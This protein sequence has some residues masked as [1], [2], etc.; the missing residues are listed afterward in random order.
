MDFET[1]LSE[2]FYTNYAEKKGDNYFGS[3]YRP[4]ETMQGI[5]IRLN[6]QLLEETNLDKIK[7]IT[8]ALLFIEYIVND[9]RCSA[10]YEKHLYG[11][12]RYD[13]R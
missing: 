6:T 8:K 4:G 11:Q 5:I 3:M 9:P 2:Y 1:L 12:M 13:S 10:E 7:L